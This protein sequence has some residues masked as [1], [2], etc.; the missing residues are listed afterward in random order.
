MRRHHRSRVGLAWAGLALLAVLAGAG[1]WMTRHQPTESGELAAEKLLPPS[2]THWFGTDAS[3]RDVFS[4]MAYGSR[5]SLGIAMLAV[6]VV[7]V[8]GVL[9]GGVAGFGPPAVDRWMMRGVDALLATPR[10]LLVLTVVALA[11]RPGP[12]ALALL[13]GLTGWGPVSRV[14]RERVRELRVSGFVVAARAIGTTPAAVLARHILPGVI[15]AAAAA[16]V[17]TVATVVPLEAALG[18][19]GAGVA[20]PTPTWGAILQEAADSPLDHWWLLVFPSAAIAITLI[21]V[22]VIGDSLA[23]RHR[24]GAA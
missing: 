3:A 12:V 14:V 10:L 7:L 9:W 24:E 6:A 5:T 21:S 8:A 13:L 17:V 22:H 2:G 20:P 23:Q 4:R 19:V 11:G 16:A 1:P 15:P 18:Y